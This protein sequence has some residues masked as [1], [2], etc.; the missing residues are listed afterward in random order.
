MELPSSKEE[1]WGRGSEGKRR[2]GGKRGD[3]EG[4]DPGRYL[5]GS[6]ESESCSRLWSDPG[7]DGALQNKRAAGQYPP[8]VPY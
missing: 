2:G 6:A 5:Q 1:K 3:G 4:F 8:A 7:V